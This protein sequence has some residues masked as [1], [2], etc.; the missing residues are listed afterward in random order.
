MSVERCESLR[1]DAWAEHSVREAMQL[2][3]EL[4]LPAGRKRTIDCSG[5]SV[6]TEY[7]EATQMA[8]NR[9]YVNDVSVEMCYAKLQRTTADK[10]RERH[11]REYHSDPLVF[12][13]K[14]S[15]GEP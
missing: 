1:D 12:P 7:L 3:E 15:K 10:I 5:L 4:S 8:I 9:K 13:K 11:L 14:A 2:A 6:S